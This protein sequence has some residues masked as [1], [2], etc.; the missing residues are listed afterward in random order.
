MKQGR[1]GFHESLRQILEGLGGSYV[2]SLYKASAYASAI[3]ISHGGSCEIS[4]GAR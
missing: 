3:T 1:P 4:V 2:E